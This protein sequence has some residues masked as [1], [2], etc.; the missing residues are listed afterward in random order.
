[1]A[2]R[3]LHAARPADIREWRAPVTPE[4]VGRLAKLGLRVRVERGL[5]EAAGFPD[6]AYEEAGAEVTD[7]D[8]SDAD[9]VARVDAPSAEAIDRLKSGAL[10]VSFFD[11]FENGRRLRKCAERGV[12][13]ASL[14]MIPRTA[15]AQKMD[16]LTSQANLAGY[17]AVVKAA[18]MLGKIFPMMMTPAGT[19][20]PANVFVV[21]AGVAGLQAI[22]TAKRLGARIQAFD[23]RPEVK[24][25]VES[26]GGKFLEIDLGETGETDQGYAR[27]LAEA[28]KEKQ[29]AGMR[30]ACAAADVVVTTAKVFGRPAPKIVDAPMLDA[31]RPGGVVVDMAVES[32]GNVEG[33]RPNE[34]VERANGVRV[35]GLDKLESYVAR[36]ASRM[37]A[38]N[39]ASLVEHFHGGESGEIALDREDEII[40][41]CLLT[42]GGEIVHPRFREGAEA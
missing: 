26:L 15:L 41:G 37:L 24:E 23:T 13:A 30:K 6:A 40:E 35:C 20:A 31:M 22:A 9:I 36:D 4:T 5:G 42:R 2:E 8:A 12:S 21:G 28:Q 14:E 33:A 18:E 27:E 32:G 11:P 19:I 29:K 7:E 39:I 38:S 1:M 25:Q 10:H 16:A 17:F 3:I 34:I